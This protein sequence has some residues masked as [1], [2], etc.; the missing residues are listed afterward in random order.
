MEQIYHLVKTPHQRSQQICGSLLRQKK[1]TPNIQIQ[2]LCT[3]MIRRVFELRSPSRACICN[4]DIEFPLSLLDLIHESHDLS[5]RRHVRW[6][7]DCP[8]LHS[9]Q[10]VELLDSLIDSLWPS[11][12]ASCDEDFLCSG[13]QECC[14]GMKTQSSGT[15]GEVCSVHSFCAAIDPSTHLQLPARLFHPSGTYDRSLEVQTL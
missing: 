7:T 14:R 8:P 4:K 9:W 10:L 1:N 13:A 15:C 12:F 2:D 11:G 6:D 5:F 3:R